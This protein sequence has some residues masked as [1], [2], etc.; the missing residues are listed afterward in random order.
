MSVSRTTLDGRSINS[1][2]TT[3][4]ITL[5]MGGRALTLWK[6]TEKSQCKSNSWQARCFLD[7][8]TRQISTRE[9]DI[10]RAKQE[11]L[12][13]YGNLISGNN[14]YHIVSG[15]PN[16]FE[17]VAASY[18]ERCENLVRHG[19]RHK[20]FAKDIQIRYKNYLEPFFRNDSIDQIT[21]PRMNAWL[22]WRGNQRIS[23]Q[24]LLTAELR[25][26]ITILRAMLNEAVSDGIIKELPTFPP[27]IRVETISTK[28]TP[29][30]TY[31]N[32]E[33]IHQLLTLARKRIVETRLLVENPPVKGG[34]YQKIL[35]DREYLL[36]YIYWLCGTGMRPGE[37]QRVKLKHITE[38]TCEVK[39]KN[40]LSIDVIGKRGDRQVIT[41]HY[42]YSVFQDIKIFFKAQLKQDDLLFPI[43]PV[44]GLKSLLIAANLRENSRG[45]RRDAKSFRHYYI[46]Q[47]LADGSS[48]WML[49][50]QCDVDPTIIKKHYARHMTPQQY[51]D[52]LIRSS[53]NK[54][55]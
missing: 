22:R 50:V 32:G 6:W 36:F 35:R 17:Q 19:K 18:I 34:N 15:N 5:D 51:K 14:H 45:E 27:S 7:G 42:L 20:T 28:K 46:M 41:K 1:K 44:N 39:T 26:E 48:P 3:E 13:W 4:R 23:T 9:E 47:A 49:S 40:Y 2:G 12:S 43:S 16:K 52:E 55:I 33:E 37:A 10:K 24:L 11:A 8:R 29:A 54:L 53:I 38:H 25:K 21:T 31:F 30:R